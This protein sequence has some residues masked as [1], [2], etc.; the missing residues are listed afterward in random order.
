MNTTA[1]NLA[2]GLGI[3]ATA[4]GSTISTNTSA[5][6]R[7]LAQAE[8][9]N[10]SKTA[11]QTIKIDGSST[12][13]PITQAIAKLFQADLSNKGQVE[14]KISGTTGGF[15]K[16]CTGKTDINNASRP[17][18]QAEMETCKKNGVRFM[19]FP[20]AFDALTIAVNPQNDWAKDITIAELKKMWEPAAQGKILRWNQVRPTW[21]DRPLKLFGA[22]DKSGTFDYFTEATVGK[23]K[24][25]RKD[26]TPSEDDEVLVEGISKDPNALGYFGFAYYQEN[27]SKL[28][29]LAVDSGKGAILPSL[30]TVEKNQYQPLSRP[31]FIY[32]NPRS[33]SNRQILGK[34]VRLYINKAATIA[35]SVGYVPLPDAV[36]NINYI[37][38]NRGKTGTA[39]GGK[40]RLNAK[41]SDLLPKKAE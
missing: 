29:L 19:E 26:Y 25:S 9:D 40:A 31:L 13:F 11:A 32:V 23:A 27:K 18:L 35:D 28:K 5:Q 17:I 15:E 41:I 24:L 1:K 14:V 30:Q 36:R 8:G 12:V 10:P 33:S 38:F 6:V 3:F 16:F 39:F 7:S 34:F 2:I 37:H 20:I 21:P 4:I 22:G